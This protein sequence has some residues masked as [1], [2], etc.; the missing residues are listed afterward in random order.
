M[1]KYLFVNKYSSEGAAA[2]L[3]QG[4]EERTA[5]FHEMAEAMGATIHGYWYSE[6][7]RVIVIVEYP[8]GEHPGVQA[9]GQLQIAASG[10]WDE[11]EVH[12]LFDPTE[13]VE[14]ANAQ[15]LVYKPPGS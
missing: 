10:A 8:D 9:I 11:S 1:T 7:G 12:R 6:T 15:K 13:V 14:A 3:E 5:K 4:V 2:I